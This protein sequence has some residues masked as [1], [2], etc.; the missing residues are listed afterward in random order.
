MSNE[1]REKLKHLLHHWAEHNE[2]HCEK[3]KEW[4]QKAKEFGDIKVHDTI[5][6][7]VRSTDK[8][9]ESLRAALDTL[10]A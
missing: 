2:E 7:A 1:D 3:Y 8:T 5:M 6:E 9:N 4:A 10:K